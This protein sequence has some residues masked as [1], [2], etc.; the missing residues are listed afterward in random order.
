MA[1][2]IK[3]SVI[4]PV[5]NAHSTLVRCLGNL[6]NQTL[7]EL[8][9]ILVNDASTDDSLSILLECERQFPDKIL[10]V[11]S[12]ENRGP[13][14]ARNIGLEY[15]TGEYIGFVDSDDYVDPTMYEK[16]YRKAVEQDYDMVDCGYFYEK[17]GQSIVMT[18]EEN[19][20]VLD[21]AKRNALMVGGGYIV[22]RLFKREL[23]D[24]E[25]ESFRFREKAILEDM[26]FLQYAIAKARSIGIVKEV[27]YRYT[28]DA[29][30]ISESNTK[31]IYKYYRNITGA[32]TALY[33][34]MSPLPD[35]RNYQLAIEY[36]LLQLYLYGIILCL[37]NTANPDFD[38]ATR[39]KL[40]RKLKEQYVTHP[41][42]ENPYVRDKIRNEDYR[43]LEQYEQ[44]TEHD[45]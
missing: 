26:E 40:L 24:A 43:L 36:E 16:L 2:E 11:N 1:S 32:M 35:Y 45:I 25:P 4:V 42:R 19:T 44:E 3:V 18:A 28:Y 27:L 37:Q 20:G 8:Q 5:Y 33:E 39:L 22:T 13:G 7:P 15:A 9:L 31:D 34:K 29:S 38:G 12:E 21:T 10:V 30:N 6:V 17:T 23:F 14:G 41:C